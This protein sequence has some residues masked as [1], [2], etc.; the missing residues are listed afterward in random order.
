MTH[1]LIGGGVGAQR[2]GGGLDGG[3]GTGLFS[4]FINNIYMNGIIKRYI[5]Q[6]GAVQKLYHSILDLR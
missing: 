4:Q 3:V 5:I 1:S 6:L 2:R